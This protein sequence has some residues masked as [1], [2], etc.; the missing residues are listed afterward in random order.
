MSVHDCVAW[1]EVRQPGLVSWMNT[2]T[3]TIIDNIVDPLRVIWRHGI[4]VI[5]RET[6]QTPLQ[7]VREL[8]FGFRALSDAHRAH[9]PTHP[10]FT[11]HPWPMP[12]IFWE[13]YTG[14]VVLPSEAKGAGDRLAIELDRLS[15]YMYLRL[16]ISGL[17][18]QAFKFITACKSY[19][20][21][22]PK[23]TLLELLIGKAKRIATHVEVFGGAVKRVPGSVLR[24]NI[25]IARKLSPYAL[26]ILGCY[27]GYK[28]LVYGLGRLAR[29]QMSEVWRFIARTD[30][31]IVHNVTRAALPPVR[32]PE[33]IVAHALNNVFDRESWLTR[34]VAWCDRTRIP[35]LQLRTMA[36]IAATYQQAQPLYAL[37]R[38]LNPRVQVTWWDIVSGTR[39]LHSGAARAQAENAVG[40]PGDQVPNPVPPSVVSWFV[41]RPG[42]MRPNPTCSA[43]EIFLEAVVDR[44]W[45]LLTDVCTLPVRALV[46]SPRGLPEINWDLQLLAFLTRLGLPR[47]LVSK[48]YQKLEEKR[49]RRR[50]RHEMLRQRDIIFMVRSHVMAKLGRESIRG[51]ADDPR[52]RMVVSRSV[53]E[54][55]NSL[56]I[57]ISRQSM[58]NDACI[59]ACFI[60][61]AYDEAGQE[62]HLGPAARA[63]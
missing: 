9:V 56:D 13:G 57:P 4:F 59:E 55:M 11:E 18:E 51:G 41:P 54:T 1:V 2:I 5:A 40:Q 28:L 39:Y 35:R 29:Q 14:H 10:P 16:G 19:F 15:E 32:E 25:G 24:G 12:G 49:T 34:V 50:A 17:T 27:A 31:A 63:L 46:W 8:V 42:R 52:T 30:L 21:P 3:P 47:G 60:D 45:R 38:R 53:T 20:L 43:F 6:D 61:T 37:V 7:K 62:L 26:F 22:P 23:P 33:A 58:I 48:W 44:P 36:Q